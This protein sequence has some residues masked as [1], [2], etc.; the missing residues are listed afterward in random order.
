MVLT[1]AKMTMME[2]ERNLHMGGCWR[3]SKIPLNKNM[4]LITFIETVLF[5]ILILRQMA[6]TFRQGHPAVTTDNTDDEH[7]KGA[8]LNDCNDH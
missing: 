5:V 1:H 4:V 8:S 6:E 2:I 7:D 3:K